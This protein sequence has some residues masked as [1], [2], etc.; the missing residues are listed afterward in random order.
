[1]KMAPLSESIWAGIPQVAVALRKQD[2]TSAA[3]NVTRVSE[4]TA[5]R[6][7]SSSWLRI[8]TSV[9]SARA[10]WVVSSCQ[11]SLGWSA[12]KRI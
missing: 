7:W 11:R 10:Q 9:P 8:S 3:L 5:R 2:T 6:E 12:S 4:P 1:V